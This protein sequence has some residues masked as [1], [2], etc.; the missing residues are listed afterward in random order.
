[1]TFS[2]SWKQGNKDHAVVLQNR[3]VMIGSLLSSQVQLQGDGVDPIHALL[4]SK[5]S[6]WLLTDLGAKSGVYVNGK[7]ISV[8]I[9]LKTGDQIRI[10]S[11]DIQYLELWANG[12]S[13]SITTADVSSSIL[14]KVSAPEKSS[15]KV[16][17]FT[18]FNAKENLFAKSQNSQVGETVEVIS[19]WKNTVLH[20]EH[21]HAGK[22][23]DTFVTIGDPTKANFIAA[24]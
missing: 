14:S 9:L 13:T 6:G 5:E 12:H 21:F 24:G 16:R 10:G 17:P 22:D 2:L 19:Y 11:V 20:V 4:E 15:S 1:M 8:E 18:D 7:K 3:T 23:G